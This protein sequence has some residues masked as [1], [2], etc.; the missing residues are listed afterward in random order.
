MIIVVIMH[1]LLGYA[2]VSGLAKKV[3]DVVKIVEAKAVDAP[4]PP[5]PPPPKDLPPPPKNLPPPPVYVPPPPVD[6]PPPPVQQQITTTS[7]MPPPAPE[8]R[9]QPP[10]PVAPV[11]TP[12]AARPAKFNANDPAC[13]PEYPPAA[14]RAGATGVT[15][16]RFVV[17]A[18]GK[19]TSA[20][21]VGSSGPT[22]EHRLLD[23][24]AKST[25]AACPFT[26]GV[27][28]EGRP[29]GTTVPVE[30]VWKLE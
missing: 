9:I 18:S 19:V 4:P 21:I 2:L 28:A 16:M 6:V 13:K 30:Y 14:V 26:P 29:T 22:R 20:E 12:V 1:L 3:V 10:A 5:P 27:D 8:P 15:K 24:A 17:D 11:A 25:I 23:N 7:V